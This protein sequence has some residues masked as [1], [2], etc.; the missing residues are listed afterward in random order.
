MP[1]GRGS[2]RTVMPAARRRHLASCLVLVLGLTAACTAPATPSPTG[3]ASPSAASS[4][5]ASQPGS[6]VPPLDSGPDRLRLEL[7]AEDLRHPIGLTSAGDGSERMFVNER[8]GGGPRDRPRRRA[9][10]PSVRGPERSHRRR[11]RARAAGPGLPSG[12]RDQSAPVRPLQPS[13]RRLD[14]G[15][16]A[17][18]LGRPAD[19]RSGQRASAVH[20]RPIRSST[21][22]AGSW[23]SGRTATCTSGWATAAVA[24]TRCRTGR[25]P[26]CC[27][28][29]SCASTW[30]RRTAVGPTASRPTTRSAWRRQPGRWAAGDLGRGPAQPV[31]LQLRPRWRR[32]LHR[33]RRPGQ[34]GGDRPPAGRLRRRRELRLERDGGAP[35]LRRRLRPD[36]L[37]QADRRVQPRPGLLGH[38]RLRVPRDG[39]AGA[40]GRLCL[41]RLLLRDNLHTAGRRRHHRPQA[42]ARFRAGH[43]LLRDR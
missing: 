6:T 5:G 21:T 36:R 28:A 23:R 16:R 42:G 26:T 30:M 39:A 12:L 15:Q 20:G 10:G 29:R 38:R 13:R 8:D 24:A 4:P 17:D 41:R 22:T 27:W 37:R 31:A 32:P 33:R 43:L 40:A 11:W 25:T 1:G 7:V 19:G 34:L 14:G 3:A 35:L 18:R 2:L 9:A